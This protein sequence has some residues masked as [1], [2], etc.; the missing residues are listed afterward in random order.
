MSLFGKYS[1]YYDLLYKDKDYESEVEY[2]H[3]LIQKNMP[4]S[5]RI[6]NLG[7]GTG[8]HDILLAEKGYHVTGVDMSEE[9]LSEA[10]ARLSSQ[11]SRNLQVNFFQGD[12]RSLEMEEQFDVVISLFHVMSYQTT[13]ED[14][15]LAFI[16]AKK[17]LCKNGFFIFDAWYGPAVLTDLPSMRVKR[18]EDD[19]IHVTRIA[20][21]LMHANKNVVDVNYTI[22]IRDKI[23]DVVHELKETHHM[24]YLF[25]PEVD[26][27]FDKSGFQ[28][29]QLEEWLTGLTPSFNSWGVCWVAKKI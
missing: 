14:L 3:K 28:L 9:M 22:F 20:E 19:K 7:C 23:N 25:K 11:D 27:L 6:L 29:I 8:K 5:K 10:K 18:L 26:I 13:N 4:G 1:S 17:H 12:I 16:S 24:R 2:I 15:N 21:P